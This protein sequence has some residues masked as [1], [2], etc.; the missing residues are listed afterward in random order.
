MDF[1][2]SEG[3]FLG[4]TLCFVAGVQYVFFKAWSF[5]ERGV[6]DGFGVSD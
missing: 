4:V 2:G 3:L 6:N 1:G 5:A